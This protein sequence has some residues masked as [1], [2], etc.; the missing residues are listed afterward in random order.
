MPLPS[1]GTSSSIQTAKRN[2]LLDHAQGADTQTTSK[3]YCTPLY[4]ISMVLCKEHKETCD[5]YVTTQVAWE[6]RL[7]TAIIFRSVGEQRSVK[8]CPVNVR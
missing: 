3:S 2:N 7:I 8:T 6:W 4:V 1:T 5:V